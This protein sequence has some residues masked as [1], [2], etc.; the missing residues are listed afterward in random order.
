MSRHRW[1]S[2]DAAS[3]DVGLAPHHRG[4]HDAP[5]LQ[6]NR[7][8]VDVT[9]AL[10]PQS[11]GHLTRPSADR[12]CRRLLEQ[13][14]GIDGVGGG[15][16]FATPAGPADRNVLPSKFRVMLNRMRD[17]VLGLALDKDGD[18]KNSI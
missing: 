3:M 6:R 10:V 18:F 14:I 12:Q 4:Q 7:S 11:P 2:T 15:R 9:N 1:L 8:E 16:E 5:A 13:D 17:P